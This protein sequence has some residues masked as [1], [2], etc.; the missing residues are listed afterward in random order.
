[1]IRRIQ[2]SR[3]DEIHALKK[4]VARSVVICLHSLTTALYREKER[5]IVFFWVRTLFLS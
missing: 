1:M 5:H 3:E 2:A 4:G